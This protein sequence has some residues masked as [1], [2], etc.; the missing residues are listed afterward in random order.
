MS[1]RCDAAGVGV[2]EHEGA[3]AELCLWLMLAVL[4]SIIGCWAAV[5]IVLWL[6]SAPRGQQRRSGC[7]M[8]GG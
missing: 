6:L 2:A 7:D 3:A 1:V 8:Q 4:L 5:R